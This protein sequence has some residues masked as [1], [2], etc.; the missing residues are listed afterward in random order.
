MQDSEYIFITMSYKE[1]MDMLQYNLDLNHNVVAIAEFNSLE[2]CKKVYDKI[3]AKIIKK[4]TL[5]TQ[6]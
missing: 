6:S 5:N 2:E 4:G 3:N 1:Y